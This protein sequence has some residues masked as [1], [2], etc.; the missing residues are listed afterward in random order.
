M[1]VS[2]AFRSEHT[3]RARPGAAIVFARHRGLLTAIAVFLLLFALVNSISAGRLTYFDISFMASGA[4]TLA[5]AAIGETI[6]ILTGGFDLS[7]GAVISLVNVVL[8]SSMDPASTHESIVLWTLAGIGVGM[9]AGVFNGFFIAFLGLQPIV[10][11]LSTM[12]IA[13][14]V[15]LLVMEKPGGFV[16]SQLGSFYL[17]D[18]IPS[19]LPMPILLIAC[20]L[21]LWLWLKSTRFGAALYAIGSD[22]EAAR[23]AGVRVDLTRFLTYTIAGGCYGLAGVFISAQTGSGDPLVGNPMLLSIFTAVVLGGTRLGGGR[24]GPTGSVFGAYILMSVVNVLLVLNVSAYYSTIAEGVILI[25]AVLAAS[26]SG[27]SELA[28]QLR[29][30]AA[31][32]SAWRAG[33][34]PRQIGGGDRRLRDHLA[35]AAKVERNGAP[36]F[37]TRHADALRYAVPSYVCFVAVV[38]VTEL[39]LG[40]AVLH[41]SYWNSLIVLS[42][43]LA[44]LALGQGT[45]ILTGGLDLCVPW[46]I[47]LSGI[48]LA[49]MVQGSDKA[50]IYALPAVFAIAAIVGFVN[51]VGI[52]ALGISPIVMTLADKRRAAG[53]GVALFRRDSCRVLFS[54]VAMVHDRKDCRHHAGRVLHRGFH[55]RRGDFAVAHAV[56]S[57]RLW[58]R[59]RRARRAAVRDCRWSNIDLGLRPLG[60]LF[61]SRRRIA[62]GLFRP[63]KPRHGRRLSVAVNRSRRGRRHDHHRRPRPISRHA[64]RR[65]ALDRAAD[66]ARRQQ[67]SLRDAGNPLWPCGSWGGDRTA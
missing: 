31:R 57:P 55:H 41:W 22:A 23:S 26:L 33:T 52:V 28:R 38:V 35:K 59:Q 13:Q 60:A 14:G 47:G 49:G 44:I 56:R 18:A 65:A 54:A 46:M 12:F 8:A 27:D 4:A 61:L 36:P 58:H 34:L 1:S 21:L 64:R 17:G 50:L 39:W 5:I 42:S 51:G 3:A 48:L 40:S 6:V 45:V 9:A 63:G 25:L 37:W 32:F 30:M 7:A 62:H 19:L 20:V 66:H 2:A 29:L 11:T 16:A 10:V 53:S 24:G 15:T 43:F 67:S